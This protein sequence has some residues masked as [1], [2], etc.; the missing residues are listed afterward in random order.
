MTPPRPS[1]GRSSAAARVPGGGK[2]V[3]SGGRGTRT[4]YTTGKHTGGGSGSGSG[5]RASGGGGVAGARAKG[6]GDSPW[7]LSP[8]WR[9]VRVPVTHPSTEQAE[10]IGAPLGLNAH[11]VKV[12]HEQTSQRRRRTEEDGVAVLSGGCA[13]MHLAREYSNVR[14]LLQLLSQYSTFEGINV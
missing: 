1:G 8:S 11:Q 4:G 6:A 9:T 13:A 12:V 3:F 7:R 5:R 14:C 10:N 2:T